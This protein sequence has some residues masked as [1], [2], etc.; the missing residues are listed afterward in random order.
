MKKCFFTILILPLTLLSQTG[1]LSGSVFYKYNDYVGPR[2]DAGAS[3]KLFPAN[4]P[5]SKKET[6]V[7]LDGSFQFSKLDTGKYLLLVKSKETNESPSMG[8][9]RL[10]VYGNLLQKYFD[11]NPRSTNPALQTAIELKDQ[12]YT[13]YL[14]S[15]NPK[16]KKL[17]DIK[18]ELIELSFRFFNEIPVEGLIRA[19][20]S[21]PTEKVDIREVAISEKE[22][23]II[24]DFGLT[25][26]N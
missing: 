13:D 19:G 25:Y 23:K 22:Q 6:L 9:T 11:F 10:I 20:I 1:N 15:K 12:E 2:P 16:Q 17:A 5:D 8:V 26:R 24:I 7:G 4:S 21:L 14:F 3:V 18:E